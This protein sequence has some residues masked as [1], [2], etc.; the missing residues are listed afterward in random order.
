MIEQWMHEKLKK[1]IGE[2]RYNHSIGVMNTSMELA[3]LYGYPEGEA[4]LA[5][6]LHDCGKLK[7]KINLLKIAK[8]FDIILDNVMKHNP[9]LIHG[10]LGEKI[11]IKEY[12]VTN[13]NVLNA[14]RYHT[15]GRENMSLLEKIVYVADIIEPGRKF[16]GVDTIRQ[17]AYE[18]IDKCLLYALD[19]TIVFV[20]SKG[21]LIHLDTIKA[22]NQLIILKDLE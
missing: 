15:T 12:K 13:K 5:G 16:E 20:I 14:I 21:K 10:P 2:V 11:A 1:D 18:D 22:R 17:L 4:E 9:E 7:D 3:K 19:R 6:F 8:E